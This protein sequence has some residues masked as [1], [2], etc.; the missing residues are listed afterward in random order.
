MKKWNIRIEINL[1]WIFNMHKKRIVFLETSHNA[2]DL[3]LIDILSY[4]DIHFEYW[5]YEKMLI[6]HFNTQTYV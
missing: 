6:H 3:K 4:L 1:K 5:A 2:E